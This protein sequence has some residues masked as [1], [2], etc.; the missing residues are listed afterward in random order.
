MPDFKLAGIKQ[1][2]DHKVVLGVA[3]LLPALRVVR[4][5]IVEALSHD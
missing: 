4:L 1:Q 3:S 5:R 2:G